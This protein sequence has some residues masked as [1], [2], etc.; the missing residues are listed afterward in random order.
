MK[1]ENKTKKQLINELIELRQ[2]I[3]EIEEAGANRKNITESFNEY[4]SRYKALFNHSLYCIYLHD[5]E[6]NLFDANPT[7]LN[8]FGYT[9]EDL[10]NLNI[11]E[12]IPKEQIPIALQRVEDIIRTGSQ[13]TPYQYRVKKKSG[14]YIWLEIE[15]AL[16]YKKGRPYAIQGLARDITKRKKAEEAVRISEEKYRDLYDNAPDMFVSVDPKTGL[17]T[18]CNKTFSKAIG[19]TKKE[20]IGR[21][22]FDMYHEDCME[23][24]RTCF[25]MFQETGEGHNAELQLKRKDG[26][27]IDVILN[28]SAVRDEKGNIIYSR[29][30]WRDI[31]D[32]KRAKEQISEHEQF[33]SSV[34]DSIQDGISILDNNLRVMHVNSTMEKWYQHAMPIVGKKCFEVYHGRSIPCKICPTQ[35]TIKTG[36]AD[37]KVVPLTGHKGKK[38]GWLDLYSFP[39]LDTKTGKMKGVI[40]YVRNITDRKQAGD[41]LKQSEKELKKRVKELE[42]FYDI[43]VG[44]ELRMVQLKKENKTLK[45]ELDE[46]RKQE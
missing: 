1:D 23:D 40:E 8:L 16:V 38:I 5:L 18:E 14:E 11:L 2:R 22:I 43:A 41:A 45:D 12:L 31:T 13:K 39:L 4:K 25:K 6:G 19:Y 44:R 20:I 33:M 46:Y 37:Y 3:L 21:P 17:I 26:T 15:G 30:I 28:V 42:E 9:K 24:V 10:S 27:K 36:K 29:S 35:K 7:A 32:L 34:F